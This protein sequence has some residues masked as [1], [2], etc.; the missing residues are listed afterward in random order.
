M[1]AG[2]NRIVNAMTGAHEGG[3]FSLF[4]AK[5]G[6]FLS[7]GGKDRK[8]V[9]W[10]SSTYSKTGKETEVKSLKINK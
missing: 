7:G 4:A 8:I 9:Q 10:D 1:I 6:T 5:D 2:S 3:I